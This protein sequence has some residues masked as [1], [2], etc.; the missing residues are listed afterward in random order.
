MA[1]LSPECN[2]LK[3]NY[4]NCFNEWYSNKF[5]RGDTSP[6]CEKEFKLYKACLKNALTRLDLES[7]IEEIRR[8]N[9]S[10][11]FD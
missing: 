11:K 8:E 10:L 4:D 1:S 7:K 6:G 9:P 5:L 2:E 3:K